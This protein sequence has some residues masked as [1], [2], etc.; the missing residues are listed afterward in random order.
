MRRM[1]TTR[2]KANSAEKVTQD[3]DLVPLSVV[4]ELLKAQETTMKSFLTTFVEETSKRIDKRI[5]DL[6]KEVKSIIA[7]LEFTQ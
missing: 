2:S 3:G 6:S 4:K 7:S 1:T 5:D